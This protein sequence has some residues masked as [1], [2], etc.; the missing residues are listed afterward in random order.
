[1]TSTCLLMRYLGGLWR[2][3]SGYPNLRLCALGEFLSWRIYGWG[4]IIANR[5]YFIACDPE[6]FCCRSTSCCSVRRLFSSCSVGV[7]PAIWLEL[8]HLLFRSIYLKEIIL[9]CK[10]YRVMGLLVIVSP[11]AHYDE[12]YFW[13]VDCY[14]VCIL[15]W[16][17]T[18]LLVERVVCPFYIE[19]K[20][21]GVVLI[22]LH[23]AWTLLS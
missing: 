22:T 16:C 9:A 19:E 4:N 13:V 15:S 2:C 14:S 5:R 21:I 11:T 3:G 12:I 18:Q 6:R 8:S 20:L 23:P 17:V 7:A 1:M 10:Q